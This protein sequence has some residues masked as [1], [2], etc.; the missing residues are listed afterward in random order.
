MLQH[1]KPGVW[2]L[3]PSRRWVFVF[4]Q[5][6]ITTVILIALAAAAFAQQ[7]T[8][9]VT[10]TVTDPTGALVPGVTI[11]ATNLATNG[12]RETKSDETGSYTLPFLPAG[13]YS[14]TVGAPGFQTQKIDRVTL[15]VQQTARVDLQLRIGDVAETVSVEAFA[16]A[17]QTDNA[18]VGTVIDG[19]KIVDLPLNGRN[20]V[21]LAQLIPGVQAGTPG[22]ITV[23]RGR[24]SIGQQD[25]PFGSTAMSANGSRDTANRYLLDGIRRRSRRADQH[26]YKTR[27]QSLD[28]DTLGVQSQRRSDPGIRCDRRQKCCT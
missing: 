16:V 6:L 22:S 20:F 14:V 3:F 19:A 8:A 13:D 11:T 24:G 27:R 17:L 1:L 28:R 9:T 18:T 26:D 21:Q 2:L 12:V 5:R 23:R 10:G 4:F 25:A 15:Q 7:T